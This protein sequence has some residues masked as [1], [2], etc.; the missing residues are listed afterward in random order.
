MEGTSTVQV[1]I[2][3][4]TAAAHGQSIGDISVII[5]EGLAV[6]LQKSA[7]IALAACGQIGGKVRRQADAGKDMQI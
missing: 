2:A 3:T 7:E 5:P 1:V 6:S 4:A